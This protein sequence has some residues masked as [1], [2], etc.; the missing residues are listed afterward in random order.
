M[1]S[2]AQS[3]LNSIRLSEN[4]TSEIHDISGFD[5]IDVS[6]DFKVYVHF[7]DGPEKV[8]IEANENLHD[9]I[10]VENDG[11]TLKIHMKSYNIEGYGKRGGAQERLVAHITAQ[12]LNAIK[13]EEDVSISLEDELQSDQLSI[14]LSED[15]I[16]KGHINVKDL[17]V[18]L[19]EDSILDIEGSARSMTVQAN[20]DSTIKGF[21]LV[22][23]Q[24]EIE[25]NEDSQAKLTVNG[26]IDLVAK[27]DSYFYYKGNP[28]FTRKRLRGDSE[29]KSY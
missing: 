28:N 7:A 27:D 20:E 26:D 25:L 6:E 8:E 3:G 15:C 22:V 5:K 14:D 23:G 4:I 13:G 21:E 12:N 9:L 11:G 2:L 19:D 29:V 17:E 10:V 18:K 24:L 1:H 16:L